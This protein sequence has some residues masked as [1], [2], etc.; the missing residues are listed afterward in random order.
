MVTVGVTLD[1][2]GMA[3]HGNDAAFFG[4]LKVCSER[5]TVEAIYQHN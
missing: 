1:V 2:I 5:N 3:D 4:R